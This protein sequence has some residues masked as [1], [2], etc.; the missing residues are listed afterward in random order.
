MLYTVEKIF[1]YKTTFAKKNN[2]DYYSRILSFK[3][4]VNFEACARE[5]RYSEL[6]SISNK[7]ETITALS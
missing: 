2:V 1:L 4:K 6:E 5:K 7:L 3:K